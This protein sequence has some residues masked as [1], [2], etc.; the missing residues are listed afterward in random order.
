MVRVSG[1]TMG[2]LMV[3]GRPPSADM[4]LHPCSLSTLNS[5]ALVRTRSDGCPSM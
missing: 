3:V 1:G 4:M 2:P 5:G